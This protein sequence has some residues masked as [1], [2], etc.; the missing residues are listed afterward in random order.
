MNANDAK[1][2]TAQAK[3]EDTS[4]AELVLGCWHRAI[5]KAAK[6]G[7][8]SV[9]ESEIDRPRTPIPEASRKAA[10]EILVREGFTVESAST[11]INETELE[12]SW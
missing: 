9:R 7:R 12:V 2:L 6:A 4:K 5:E 3:K 10:R 11:G 8:N 1:A